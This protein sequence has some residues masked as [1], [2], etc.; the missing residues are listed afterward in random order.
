MSAKDDSFLGATK[1]DITKIAALIV[2]GLFSSI[3]VVT[4]VFADF[5]IKITGNID[6]SLFWATFIGIVL[7][8]FAYLGF[9]SQKG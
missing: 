7:S 4:I 2:L 9:K 5:D 1:T 8:V 6:A 3:L